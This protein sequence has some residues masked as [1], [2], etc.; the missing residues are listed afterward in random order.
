MNGIPGVP[1]IPPTSILS[2]PK[3][4]LELNCLG[5]MRRCSVKIPGVI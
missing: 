5:K 2:Y 3:F 4:D 1:S